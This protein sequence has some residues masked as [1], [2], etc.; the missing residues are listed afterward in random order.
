MMRRER[1]ERESVRPEFSTPAALCSPL[2]SGA[3]AHK[4]TD[5]GLGPQPTTVI[6]SRIST[7]STSQALREKRMGE[8]IPTQ[9]MEVGALANPGISDSDLDRMDRVPGDGL[10]IECA[11]N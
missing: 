10:G 5:P 1:M 4:S 8:R 6:L 3:Q 2:T 11:R 7:D 9:N